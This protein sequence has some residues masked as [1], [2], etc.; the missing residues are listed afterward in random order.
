MQGRTAPHTALQWHDFVHHY[1]ILSTSYFPCY[2]YTTRDI[3][4]T[5]YTGMTL[6]NCCCF[7]DTVHAVF[8]T[9]F[10]VPYITLYNYY[11]YFQLRTAA[12][13]LTVRS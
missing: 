11:Y 1:Y 2:W 4:P 12:L 3:C 10:F 6:L 7:L 9:Y 8:I 13:R 5:R